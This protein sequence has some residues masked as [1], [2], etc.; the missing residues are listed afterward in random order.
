[1]IDDYGSDF[2]HYLC[3]SSVA[4]TEEFKPFFELAF[5][6]G[7]HPFTISQDGGNT[8]AHFAAKSGNNMALQLF[9]DTFQIPLDFVN[10]D[11]DSYLHLAVRSF[12][13]ETVKLL[14][15]NGADIYCSNNSRELPADFALANRGSGMMGLLADAD[16]IAAY[17]SAPDIWDAVRDGNDELVLSSL[18]PKK[19]RKKRKKKTGVSAQ[20]LLNAVIMWTTARMNLKLLDKLLDLP[21]ANTSFTTSTDLSV[22]NILCRCSDKAVISDPLFGEVLKKVV[23]K[24]DNVNSRPTNG[25]TCIHVAA[26]NSNLPAVKFLLNSGA[27]LNSMNSLSMSELHYAVMSGSD[28]IVRNLLSDGSDPSIVLRSGKNCSEFAGL[29]GQN[30]IKTILDNVDS[31]HDSGVFR[32]NVATIR[33]VRAYNLLAK[34]DNGL[35]DPYVTFTHRCGNYVFTG[36]TKEVRETLEPT[37]DQVFAFVISQ[38]NAVYRN[39]SIS[40]YDWDDPAENKTDD[41]IGRGAIVLDTRQKEQKITLALQDAAGPAGFVEIEIKFVKKKDSDI[42]KLLQNNYVKFDSKEATRELLKTSN[43][44]SV[45][46]AKAALGFVPKYPVMIIPG[47][48]SSALECWQAE[49]SSWIRERIW[50]DPFKIGHTVVGQA[51]LNK[52]SR[53]EGKGLDANQRVWLKHMLCADDGFS[54]PEGIC[55]RPVR[56][57]HA[58]DFLADNP[59]AKGPSYVFGHLIT[60][61]CDVGY[62]SKTLDAAT[63]DWRLPPQKLE[64]RDGYFSELK[65]K[66]QF[67]REQNNERVVLMAH[68]MG[69]RCAQYFLSWLR[70]HDPE[71][72]DKNIHAFMALGPPFLGASKTIRATI[73]GD[74]CGLEAFLTQEEGRAMHRKLGSVPWLLPVHEQYFPDVIT[75]V[76]KPDSGKSGSENRRSSGLFGGFKRSNTAKKGVLS[77]VHRTEFDE[78]NTES[79]LHHDAPTTWEFYKNFYSSDDCYL[80]TKPGND[81][82]ELLLPPPVENLWVVIGTNLQ[83]EVS[84][85]Y[86]PTKGPDGEDRLILD[87]SADQYSGKKIAGINPRGLKIQGGTGFE[88]RN[89]YQPSTRVNKSGDGTVP[90]CSLN[91]AESAWREY[92]SRHNLPI[93]IQTFELDGVEHREMLNDGTCFNCILDLLCVKPIS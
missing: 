40:V 19:K 33:F 50:V 75:R 76:K 39:V 81:L 9:F 1:M 7:L 92:V 2:L 18:T 32:P 69:N 20:Q 74:C 44:K 70:K 59:L 5:A 57:L 47:F 42:P 48:A 35:S 87:S 16:S 14:M 85:Y 54:D 10:R 61:L 11:G 13:V 86:K 4:H 36:K 27:F 37:W 28:D 15:A 78:H 71:W 93:K 80:E 31:S 90:Y 56:G 60:E 46:K 43:Q 45:G 83:T 26:L 21:K 38:D 89:T 62:T 66:I 24:G 72:T 51:L 30:D 49:K 58:T 41:L 12:Q 55:V 17:F 6:K 34:D 67:M 88:T 82:P 68:S 65:Y 53:N 77:M 63:Y 64:E 3:R 79:I 8:A 22:L 23:A 29:I 25:N 91:Y 84:Y 73:S 52:L